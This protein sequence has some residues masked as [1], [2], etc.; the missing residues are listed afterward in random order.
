MK[1]IKTIFWNVDTQYD[2][3]RNDDSFQGL[4]AIPGAREIEGN[5]ELLTN[6]ARE[7]R[8]QVVNTADW[9]NEYS[10][11]LSATPDFKTTFP[12]HCMQWTKGAGWIPATMP[13]RPFAVYWKTENFDEKRLAGHEGDIVIYKDEF[14]V[15]TGSRHTEKILEI[16]KPEIAIVYGVAT[17]VCVDYAVRGLLE[18]NVRVYV[19]TD[20]IKELPNL[21]LQ[22]TL[23][24]WVQKNAILTTTDAIAQLLK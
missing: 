11:E 6:I 4:L 16:I 12:K 18:R 20:A 1:T 9:H 24:D 15:F 21:P 22:E 13:L 5:L 23:D 14:D 10:K 7:K 17:N 8:I 19:P 2:F 3:M